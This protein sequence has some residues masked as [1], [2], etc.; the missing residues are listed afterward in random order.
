MRIAVCKII[1]NIYNFDE[2]KK[3]IEVKYGLLGKISKEEVIGLGY[4]VFGYNFFE[5]INGEFSIIIFDKIKKKLICIRDRYGTNL[6]FFSK[7]KNNL[8]FSS[9]IKAILKFGDVK[10]QPNW[11]KLKTF[12]FKN[13]RYSFGDQTTS[14]DNIYLI[15]PNSINIW[16]SFEYKKITLWNYKIKDNSKISLPT[17]E[18]NFFKLLENSF[19]YREDNIDEGKKAFLVSGGLILQ[20]LH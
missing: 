7:F 9:E 13:Y 8:V 15:P 10:K 6:I 17:A 5:K 11:E 12:L 4:K 3:I 19:K 20:L 14:F 18:K 16:T 1:G 2:L